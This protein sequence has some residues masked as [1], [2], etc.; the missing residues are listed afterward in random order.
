MKLRLTFRKLEDRI[1]AGEW[2][3][4]GGWCLCLGLDLDSKLWRCEKATL[5]SAGAT[6]PGFLA[7]AFDFNF[8]CL[9]FNNKIPS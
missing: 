1:G 4:G 6:H 3:M 2:V 7:F 5:L 9:Q 8:L